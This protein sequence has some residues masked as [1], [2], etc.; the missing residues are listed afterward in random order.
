MITSVDYVVIAF[1]FAFMVVIGVAFR[2]MSKDSSDYFRGGGSML[3]W[4]CGAS[5]LMVNFSAWTFTGAA[6]MMY[7]TGPLVLALYY[8]NVVGLVLVYFFTS[9][10]YR[11]LRVVT[12]IE[13]VRDR[14]GKTNEQIYV[15]IQIPLFLLNGAIF[16]NALGVF[17][18][19]VFGLPM[20]PT[21]I[22]VGVAVLL[23]SV[24]GGVW[25]VVASDFVQMLIIM[26]MT[27]VTAYLALTHPAVGGL[28][29]LLEN[30]P[31]SHRDLSQLIRVE[32]IVVWVLALLFSQSIAANN[33]AMGASRYLMVKDGSQARQATII[34][35]VGSIILP[36]VWIIPPL[37]AT[38]THPDMAATF[39][40]LENPQEASYVA[41]LSSLPNRPDGLVGLLVCGIFAA[42]M[43]TMDS[44]L[45]RSAGV[46]VRNFYLPVL[47]P[48]ASEANLLSVGRIFTVLFGLVTIGCGV[49][50]NLWRDLGLFD[51]V[52]Q[53]A[54]KIE[55]PLFM[56]MLL[57]MIVRR[58]PS[59][60]A[61]TTIPVAMAAGWLA[62]ILAGADWLRSLMGWQTTLNDM[63]IGNWNYAISIFAVVVLGTVWY[64]GGSIC[65]RSKSYEY[66]LQEDQFFARMNKPIDAEREQVPNHDRAQYRILAWLCSVYGAFVLALALLPNDLTG[67]LC[68]VFCGGV[69]LSAA[70]V[71]WIGYQRI[72]VEERKKD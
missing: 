41:S 36:L 55:I 21:I 34:P 16:L 69:V 46:F 32:L 7:S 42:T 63:E 47:R 6:S 70:S 9:H 29:A 11:Q 5:A 68:F 44:G 2:G 27:F 17:V 4:M 43:S 13:A 28:S 22:S 40:Q 37:A 14:F 10:R 33:L 65:F 67:R 57:G 48:A 15:W 58:T 50:M 35:I 64:V 51:L 71:L 24:T 49:L 72:G 54:A 23:M 56:P 18:S 62:P 45:N 52:L 66:R 39:P 1:Y 61:W 19:A 8:A 31:A 30:I 59:W 38:I 26:A 20:T 53:V 12:Y 60:I 3:W 25:A